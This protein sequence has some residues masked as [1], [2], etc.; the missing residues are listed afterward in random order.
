MQEQKRRE[1][2]SEEWQY[3]FGVQLVV[4]AAYRKV[5]DNAADGYP[6]PVMDGFLDA[7]M[8]LNKVLA[9]GDAP[10]DERT[11]DYA[12]YLAQFRRVPPKD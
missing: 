10:E 8:V 7:R 9:A 2:E 12:A 4:M 1:S 11:T 3:A 6:L 5:P